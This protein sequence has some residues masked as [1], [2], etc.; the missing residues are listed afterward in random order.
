[1]RR[2]LLLAAAAATAL[3]LA[4]CNKRPAEGNTAEA[5][6]AAMNA[7][8]P[9]QSGPVNAAQ[10]AMG[11][12]VGA[13]SA[14]TV[15]ARDTDAFV[16]NAVEGNMYEIKA[17]AIAAER[18]TSADV[19]A[20]AKMMTVDHTALQN[21][22]KPLITKAGKTAPTEL[23][24]RRQ[25]FLDNLKA[26]SAADF[27]KVYL[28]QQVAGHEETLTLMKGYAEHGDNA[29]LKAAAAKTAPKVQA[30][31]DKAKALQAKAGA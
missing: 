18:S 12:A 20:F 16:Q 22:L 13:T 30:H 3:S 24:Q 5:N 28:D 21:Q 9:G 6:T 19:K 2:A 15:G 11:A 27:N 25:G 17:A 29:E 10:D 4:A 31:L 1:M 14:A 8:A 26:A 23:D 7:T